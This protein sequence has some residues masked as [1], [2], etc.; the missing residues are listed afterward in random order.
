MLRDKLLVA[1]SAIDDEPFFRSVIYLLDAD[2]H[3]ALGIILNCP[4]ES[5]V[6]LVFPEW[7]LSVDEPGRLY[8][9]G[10]VDAS[11]AIA[12][13]IVHEGTNPQGWQ[14]THGRVGIVDLDGPVPA[15][16]EFD[17]LRLY[18]GYAGWSPGQLEAEIADGTWLVVDAKVRDLM[19]PDPETLWRDVL[20]RQTDDTRF[21][22]TL[23][24]RLNAN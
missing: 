7:S 10:P 9:G 12:V 14:P 2:E 11:S 23:P 13:G 18:A 16:G 8:L 15:A 19:H 6:Q 21:W 4:I 17:G 3:G 1:T 5:D 20:M 22:A 24:E